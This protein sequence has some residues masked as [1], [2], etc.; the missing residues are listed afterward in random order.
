MN[1]LVDILG[2]NKGKNR[3][4]ANLIVDFHNVRCGSC[5][6]LVH[7]KL[8]KDCTACGVHFGRVISNH[9]GLAEK[10]TQDRATNGN[11]GSVPVMFPSDPEDRYPSMVGG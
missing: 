10:L 6:S 5:K 8:A 11:G 3:M 1:G 7:D 4:D 2:F 9:V